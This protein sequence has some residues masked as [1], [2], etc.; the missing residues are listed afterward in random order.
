MIAEEEH[1]LANLDLPLLNRFEKM[2]FGVEDVLSPRGLALARAL[3]EWC[4]LVA[5]QSGLGSVEAAFC[6]AHV[7]LVPSLVHA[8]DAADLGECKRLLAA[9]LTPEAVVTSPAAK[10]VVSLEQYMEQQSSLRSGLGSLL[11]SARTTGSALNAVLL[12]RSPSA[13]LFAAL[14]DYRGAAESLAVRTLELALQTSEDDVASRFAA[15]L[16]SGAASPARPA[17]TRR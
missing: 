16:A 1:A 3:R 2:T 14:D 4:E 7:G 9:L 8:N 5:S 17:A 13:H 6:A 10:E 12:T 15:F 11:R